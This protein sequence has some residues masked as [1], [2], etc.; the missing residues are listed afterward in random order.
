[1]TTPKLMV[2]AGQTVEQD[3]P[4][5]QLISRRNDDGGVQRALDRT[6]ANR[7]AKKFDWSKWR[8]PEVV[9]GD[10]GYYHVIDGQHRIEAARIIANGT[11]AL[12]RCDVLQD[13]W[14]LAQQAQRF[15]G[16]FNDVKHM[17]A[18]DRFLT[19]V[20]AEDP[21][22]CAYLEIVNRHNLRPWRRGTD[23]HGFVS[24][25]IYKTAITNFGRTKAL[26]LLD[27]SFTCAVAAWG[28]AFRFTASGHFAVLY[29]LDE[30]RNLP[31]FNRMRMVEALRKTNPEKITREYGFAKEAIGCDRAAAV[32]VLAKYYNR[33]LSEAKKVPVSLGPVERA[34]AA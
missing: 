23:T 16:S 15:I 25:S 27:L 22:A 17:S 21:D 34:G 26:D 19:S 30:W 31:Q 20:V 13:T 5:S 18:A 14:T 11:D 32:A 1:M 7:I 8:K 12:V 9:L 29:A 3:I 28:M 24:P 6:H 33:G 4:L 10:D 2:F